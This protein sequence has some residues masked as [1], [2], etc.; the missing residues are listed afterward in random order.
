[1]TSARRLQRHSPKESPLLCEGAH[2]SLSKRLQDVT[3]TPFAVLK[4]AFP[5][6]LKTPVLMSAHMPLFKDAWSVYSAGSISQ[7]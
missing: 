6:L 5:G 1:M 7:A 3:A 4:C 2:L